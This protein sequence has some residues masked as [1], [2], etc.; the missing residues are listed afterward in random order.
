M[1]C[2]LILLCSSLSLIRIHQTQSVLPK[3]QIQAL[4]NLGEVGECVLHYLPLVYN[5]YGCWCGIGGAHKPIDGIDN[6]CM[7][8]DKCYDAAV[9]SKACFDVPWEYVD[10]Y[11]WKCVNSTAFCDNRNSICQSALCHCDIAVVK[12]WSQYPKPQE[13]KKCTYKRMI[14]NSIHRHFQH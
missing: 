9:D 7:Q 2:W 5:D 1:H 12:C 8:H 14:S 13:R 3:P 6:C 10:N 4:W 11:K